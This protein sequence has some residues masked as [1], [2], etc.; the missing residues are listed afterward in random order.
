MEDNAIREIIKLCQ[1]TGVR[2]HIVHLASGHSVEALEEAQN[3][4]LPITAETCH[5]YLNIAADSIPNASAQFKCCPP[6]RDSW[7]KEKLWEAI[8]KVV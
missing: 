4:G 3:T 8:K 1:E 2:T 5:H 7:H 6:I